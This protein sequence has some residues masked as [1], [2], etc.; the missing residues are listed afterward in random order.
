[1]RQRAICP[2]AAISDPHRDS[3][4]NEVAKIIASNL[5]RELVTKFVK[6]GEYQGFRTGRMWIDAHVLTP[7]QYQE[8]AAECYQQGMR[9]AS[10]LNLYNSRG[11][12]MP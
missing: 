9:D 8:F 2:D 3:C 6:H 11:E 10:M 7:E 12:M 4:I 1:M 5:M